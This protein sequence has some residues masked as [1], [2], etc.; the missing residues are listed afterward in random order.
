MRVALPASAFT[1]LR[2]QSLTGWL[3]CSRGQCDLRFSHPFTRPRVLASGSFTHR[4]E[5]RLCGAAHPAEDRFTEL[6]MKVPRSMGT[7]SE[8]EEWAGGGS[9]D[10]PASTADSAW[11]PRNHNSLRCLGGDSH[12]I[13]S[14][15]QGSGAAHTGSQTGPTFQMAQSPPR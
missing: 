14:S 8:V 5:G 1:R 11:L 13:Y 4:A 10:K 3:I 6:D 15:S 12:P 2:S 9:T 7:G